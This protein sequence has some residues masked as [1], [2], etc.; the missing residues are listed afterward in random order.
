MTGL[1]FSIPLPQ[2]ITAI[3]AVC[4]C[5]ILGRY[6]MG[7]LF[8]YFACLYWGYVANMTALVSALGGSTVGLLL[9]I[10]LGFFFAF[11]GLIFLVAPGR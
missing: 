6:K 2:L 5:L 10:A 1:Q 3:V 9:F 7:L 4:L 11:L 8:A